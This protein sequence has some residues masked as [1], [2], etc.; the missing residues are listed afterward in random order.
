[1]DCKTEFIDYADTGFFS[2]LITDYLQEA[3]HLKPFYR[4]APVDTDFEQAMAARSAFPTDRRLL[5]EELERQYAHLEPDASV[6]DNIRLLEHP[7]T[8]T[9]CTAHQPNLF[10]GYLY[11]VYKV[12]HTIKLAASLGERYPGRHFVP[13]YYM[14]SEDNDLEE[15]GTVHLGGKTYRWETTQRGAVGRMKP[16]GLETLI[17]AVTG[18]LGINESS[19]EITR[20]LREAYLEHEDIQSATQFLVNALFGRFGLVVVIADTPGFKRSIAPVLRDELFHQPSF[21]LVTHTARELSVH[22]HPQATPREINLFYLDEQLRERIVREK[23]EWKVLNTAISF[24]PET[25]EEELR[26]HPERFSP[27]V[28]LRGIL[29]ETIL[30]NIA[31]IGGGGELAY[32]MELQGVFDHFNVPFPAL[33]LRHSVLWV[34]EHASKKLRKLSLRARDLFTD[35]ETLL[36][37]YVKKNTRE[38]LLLKAEYARV[39]QLYNELEA[40]AEQIDVTLKASV[41]AERKKSLCAI[42]KLEHKFL[43]AEKKK[44]AWQA[45]AIRALRDRLFPGHGLQERVEN[46]V[47]FYATYGADFVDTVYRALD[48]LNK[49]FTLIICE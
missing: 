3:P 2:R 10:T 49:E 35:P 33:L 17:E 25:L 19:L 7:D 1:M 11:F 36:S 34:D 18:N 42:G 15:L 30:P 27:N 31:F 45:D 28:I 41:R 21:P 43:R 47:P 22:Y 6:T 8:F 20:I 5:R 32:W 29:Q 26:D 13:V 39:E 44:F 4:Y 38:D 23:D 14:G 12:L 40:R 9:I 24:T 37:E 48:P 46:I 16:E